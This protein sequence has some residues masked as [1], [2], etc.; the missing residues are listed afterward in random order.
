MKQG[1]KDWPN[2]YER[3]YRS[4]RRVWIVDC[5]WINGKR[6]RKKFNTKQ[7]AEEYAG[8]RRKLREEEGRKGLEVSLELRV[9]AAA[10]LTKLAAYPGATLTAAVDHYVTGPPVPA[11]PWYPAP[12][13][14]GTH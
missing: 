1:S 5:G 6:D 7:E 13:G 8:S 4:G 14:Y 2:I 10:C 3:I 11:R 12:S 9:E